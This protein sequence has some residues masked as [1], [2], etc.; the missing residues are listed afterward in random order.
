MTRTSDFYN[1]LVFI[2]Y[3]FPLS[4]HTC[5]SAW[6]NSRWGMGVISIHQIKRSYFLHTWAFPAAVSRQLEATGFLLETISFFIEASSFSE[7]NYYSMFQIYLFIYEAEQHMWIWAYYI[8]IL[9]V[10]GNALNLTMVLHWF[11]YHRVVIRGELPALMCKE[12]NV[13]GRS[14]RFKLGL[15]QCDFLS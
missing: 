6:P 2:W 4:F 9:Y 3:F 10:Q 13:R 7:S 12:V 5:D 11:I 14:S 15:L 8:S 1:Q